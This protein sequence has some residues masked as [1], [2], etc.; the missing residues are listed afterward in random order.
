MEDSENIEN[1]DVGLLRRA[2][3]GG[4][5]RGD[6]NR[7]LEHL[8]RERK[9]LQ[10]RLTT[11]QEAVARLESLSG[12]Q[13]A[14]LDFWNSRRDVF[15]AELRESRERA[16]AMAEKSIELVERERER[17]S[18]AAIRM[19]EQSSRE[20]NA[21]IEAARIQARDM[22]NEQDQSLA[23]TRNRVE[24]LTV[25][26]HEIKQ[27]IRGAMSR[28]EQA[29]IELGHADAGEPQP[30]EPVLRL[31]D[32]PEKV[33]VLRPMEV[34][35]VVDT[36]SPQKL[37]VIVSPFHDFSALSRFERSLAELDVVNDVYVASFVDGEAELEVSLDRPAPF[38]RLISEYAPNVADIDT[39]RPEKLIV[40]VAAAVAAS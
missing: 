11:S 13:A 31:I 12:A 40:R 32:A 28:F 23:A 20:A 17:A 2:L 39:R 18:E 6:V 25:L 24:R 7:I 38:A 14:E 5:R 33:T 16:E 36:V 30:M 15:E 37:L 10:R 8:T 1:T 19:V 4:F 22:A 34:G 27:S 21:I 35:E 26:H 29:L 9:I 3:L